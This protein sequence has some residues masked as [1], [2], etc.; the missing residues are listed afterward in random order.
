LARFVKNLLTITLLLRCLPCI[1]CYILKILKLG[2]NGREAHTDINGGRRIK[3]KKHMYPRCLL[4]FDVQKIMAPAAGRA[5]CG[6]R[7]YMTFTFSPL[8]LP[9]SRR[10][11]FNQALTIVVD[12]IL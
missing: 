4:P 3:A 7:R 2:A 5:N 6:D 8:S 11:N 9:L 10:R 12:I 1:I